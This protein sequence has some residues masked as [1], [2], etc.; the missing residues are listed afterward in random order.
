METLMPCGNDHT[1]CS[2][3]NTMTDFGCHDCPYN[4]K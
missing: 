2:L 4:K 1:D 3:W